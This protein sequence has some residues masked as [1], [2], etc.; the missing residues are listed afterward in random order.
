MQ[1]DIWN[2]KGFCCKKPDRFVILVPVNF[3]KF[4]LWLWISC[5]FCKYCVSQTQGRLALSSAKAFTKQNLVDFW[6]DL[7]DFWKNFSRQNEICFISFLFKCPWWERYRRNR[8]VRR[9]PTVSTDFQSLGCR[10]SSVAVSA[11][12]QTSSRFSLDEA[13]YY[14]IRLYSLLSNNTNKSEG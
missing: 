5:W 6:G 3:E 9:Q 12:M 4:L 7:T 14:Q 11:G 8:G 1:T 10:N 2:S 13:Q